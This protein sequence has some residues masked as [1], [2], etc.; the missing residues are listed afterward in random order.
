L[1]T[2]IDVQ[3]VAGDR[4]ACVAGRIEPPVEDVALD[5][6]RA[7]QST[8]EVPVDLRADVDKHRASP[9]CVVGLAGAEAVTTRAGL[10]QH[11]V[12]P[13]AKGSG[14]EIGSSGWSVGTDLARRNRS[15]PAAV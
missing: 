8:L 4:Q 15:R 9:Q 13:A 6:D 10:G 5:D 7:R 3:V 14:Q 2:T 11:V 1:H 12:D